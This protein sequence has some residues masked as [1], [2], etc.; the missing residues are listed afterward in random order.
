[1]YIVNRL[2][3]S[4]ID[5]VPEQFKDLHLTG[6]RSRSSI[7]LRELDRVYLKM[8]NV[9]CDDKNIEWKNMLKIV[10]HR[11]AIILYLNSKSSS[12]CFANFLKHKL[13]PCGR[14]LFFQHFCYYRETK[15]FK[16]SWNDKLGRRPILTLKEVSNFISSST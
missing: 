14:N 4:D 3:N 13:V 5:K 16:D 6:I 9:R 10:Y 11:T 12:K 7:E 1:M 15:G 2:T 8:R